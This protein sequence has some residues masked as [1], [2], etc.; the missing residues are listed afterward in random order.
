MRKLIYD[1]LDITLPKH[2]MLNMVET[3]YTFGESVTEYSVTYYTRGIGMKTTKYCLSRETV[4]CYKDNCA[5]LS[6][7]CCDIY[8]NLTK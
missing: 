2:F 8:N 5:M 6:D 7:L 1:F 4:E 3:R